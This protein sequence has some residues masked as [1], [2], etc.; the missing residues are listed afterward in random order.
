MKTS[1]TKTTLLIASLSLIG[2]LSMSACSLN[3]QI[4]ETLD[5]Q[6]KTSNYAKGKFYNDERT[7]GFEWG[8]T[9][10]I[11]KRAITE[12][13]VNTT[14][15]V[16]IPITPMYTQELLETSEDSVWRLGHSSILMKLDNE[17]VL[18]DPM[19]SERASPFSKIGP[20][21]S[22]RPS[23]LANTPPAVPCTSP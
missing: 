13:S 10:K 11:V 14:P 18:L 12:T 22:G 17:F 16:D 20:S 1:K 7:P 19:Y 8:K 15:S 23:P 4:S 2:G 5:Q 21:M 9:W 6:V 3:A